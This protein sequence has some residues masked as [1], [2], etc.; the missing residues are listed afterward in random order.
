MKIY[1]F[2]KAYEKISQ[3]YKVNCCGENVGVYSCDVSAVPFNQVWQGYQ[4]PEDQTEKSAY[5]MLSSDEAIT[6]EIEPQRSFEKVTVHPLSK[7]I[8]PTIE[9]GKVSVLFHDAGQYTVEFDNAHHVLNVFINPE[10]DF[11]GIKNN[12]NVIYFGAGVHYVD[13][14]IILKDGHTVFIDEGAVVYGAIEAVDKKDINIIGYGILDNSHMNRANEINGCAV[15][16]PNAGDMTGNPIYLNRCQNV[17]I[18]GVTL[19][20]S[21]GWNIYLD[22]CSDVTVDNIKIIGQWRYNA[23]GCDF[24]NCRNS[25][26]R[27]SF[28]RTFDDCIAIKGFKLNNNLPLENVTTENCV[29]WCDWGRNLEVGAETS[30]PYISEITFKNC[31]IIYGCHVM[32]DIQHGDK[33]KISDVRFEDIRIEYRKTTEYPLIQ[34]SEDAVYENKDETYMP[35]LFEI[36]AGTTMWSIDSCSGVLSD[37]YFK[38]ISITTEDG[39]IPH[40]SGIYVRDTENKID[41]VY[42]ENITVNGKSCDMDKLKVYIGIGANN[43]YWDN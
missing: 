33:A 28:L 17:L 14:R 30:A 41:G 2:P 21:S 18:E 22:G 4:R 11:Q 39:R 13:K 32:L 3:E 1:K 24:C 40:N 37:V 20:N 31:D 35:T 36:I 34:E 6:L 29:L 8:E 12:D 7:K 9:N 10:K 5:I 19:V 26:I 15:L 16:D 27:N 25:V 42:I 43:I 38:N 23:D